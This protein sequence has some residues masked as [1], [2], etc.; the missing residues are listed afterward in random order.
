MQLRKS[1]VV[2]AATAILDNY[3]IADLTTRR[4]AR[5]LGV[6]AGALYWHFANKQ[7]LLGA[8][9]DRILTPVPAGEPEPGWAERISSTAGRLRDAL[10][11]HTDGAELVSAT[12]AAGQSRVLDEILARFAAAAA[13]AGLEGSRAVLAARTIVHYVLGFTGDEQSRLQWDAAGAEV[14]EPP[15]DDNPSARFAFGLNLLINGIAAEIDAA[16]RKSE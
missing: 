12:F 5:E 11:S 6:T 1:D 2:D 9:A 4:L 16:A 7:E 3:G 8:V 10:L 13:A 14:A 15:A